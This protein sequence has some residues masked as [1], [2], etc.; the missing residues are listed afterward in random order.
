MAD[1]QT[2]SQISQDLQLGELTLSDYTTRSD[3]KVF[4]GVVLDKLYNALLAGTGNSGQKT[5]ADF[6][7]VLTSTINYGSVALPMYRDA[8]DL[9]QANNNKNIVLKFGGYEWTVTFLTRTGEGST[10]DHV[11][12]TLWLTDLLKTSSGNPVYTSNG[13]ANSAN[14]GNQTTLYPGDLYST[15]QARVEALNAGGVV[16]TSGN[17]ANTV[18]QNPNHQLAKFTMPSATGSLTDYI[19]KPNDVKY[20]HYENWVQQW[21]ISNGSGGYPLH[22]EALNE[23]NGNTNTATAANGAAWC[24]NYDYTGKT[25]AN[26]YTTDTAYDAWGNDY[27][28]LPS[29]SETGS[30]ISTSGSIGAIG[31]WK[32]TYN[33]NQN[34]RQPAHT[35]NGYTN[36]SNDGTNISTNIAVAGN[37]NYAWLRTGFSSIAH[38][39]YYLAGNGSYGVAY[40]ASQLAVRPA[41]HLDLTA[42]ATVAALETPRDVTQYEDSGTLKDIVYDYNKTWQLTDFG[43]GASW[44]DF[45]SYL[46]NTQFKYKTPGDTAAFTTAA[47]GAA[48]STL[49]NA[50]R[51]HVEFTLP[52]TS[53][54]KFENGA[55]TATCIITIKQKEIEYEPKLYKGNTPVNTITYGDTGGAVKLNLPTINDSGDL[56][57]AIKIYYKGTG[58][59]DTT[60]ETFDSDGY[61]SDKSMHQTHG[62]TTFPTGAGTS[63]NATIVDLNEKT[64]NYKLKLSSGASNPFAFNIGKK[65]VTLPTVSTANK[66]YNGQAQNFDIANYDPDVLDITSIEANG[67]TLSLNGTNYD[68]GNGKYTVTPSLTATPYKFTATE[69]AEYKVTWVI[70]QAA[71]TDY[72]WASTVINSD[73]TTIFTVDQASLDLTLNYPAGTTFPIGTTGNITVNAGGLTGILNSDPVTVNIGYYLKPPTGNPPATTWVQTDVDESSISLDMTNFT[74]TGTYVIWVQTSD[75]SNGSDINRNYKFTGRD[76]NTNPVTENVFVQQV[77]VGTGAVDVSGLKWGW[78]TTQGGTPTEIL[79]NS[80]LVYTKTNGAVQT[81][82]VSLIQN[83]IP[84]YLEV[85]IS[86]GSN[87]FTG[88]YAGNVERSATTTGYSAQV[89]LK[90][91]NS[92]YTFDSAD[93]SYNYISDTVATVNYTWYINAKELDFSDAVWEFS[94]NAIDEN[95]DNAQWTRFSETDTPEF[96]GSGYTYIRLNKTYLQN[97]G[98]DAGDYSVSYGSTNKQILANTSTTTN[99]TIALN[100]TNYKLQNTTPPHITYNWEIGNKKIHITGWGN[101]V[102][103][104]HDGKAYSIPRVQISNTDQDYTQFLEYVYSYQ[105]PPATPQTDVSETTMVS[106]VF[107][108]ADISNQISGTITVRLTTA[109]AQQ[110]ALD[111][112]TSWTFTCGASKTMV[113]VGIDGTHTE[114][115]DG[116]DFALTGTYH[117]GNVETLPEVDFVAQNGVKLEVT[118]TDKDGQV[119]VF[120]ANNAGDPDVVAFLSNAGVYTVD[121]KIT[122]AQLDN[123][124][125]LSDSQIIY[126]VARKGIVAPQVIKALT[127]TGGDVIFTD[128]LDNQYTANTSIIEVTGDN[129]CRNVLSNGSYNVSLKLLD[130]NYCWILPERSIGGGKGKIRVSLAAD[131]VATEL[132]LSPDLDRAIYSWN[133]APLKI[134]SSKMWNNGQLKLTPELANLVNNGFV[135]LSYNYYDSDNM[136]VGNSA[137]GFKPEGG[138]SYR[139]EAV[140]GG[141]DADMGNVVFVSS[142]GDIVGNT[143]DKVAY[144][145]KKTGMAKF[146]DTL[147]TK[148][149]G[150]PLWAWI[151]IG[152]CALILLIVLICIIVAACKRRKKKKEEEEAKKEKE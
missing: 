2:S 30:V 13:W 35:S 57:P 99:V 145:P 38:Y 110:Y 39:R 52:S 28:W 142:N 89:R 1:A 31:F 41:L 66:T 151:V 122:D 118:I 33:V 136:L 108:V 138:K 144:T 34:T 146:K 120:T 53:L 103:L 18:Q 70:K 59:P 141:D 102:T 32:T 10:S 129:N 71:Q 23:W 149:A 49:H 94:S 148:Y 74:S 93:T 147:T 26:G 131:E 127:F 62:S 27:V 8:Y 75:D 81:Y 130:N 124:Y 83:S 55:A 77:Q 98:L 79:T 133:V 5:I 113:T 7:G 44:Y 104:T 134:D 3:G 78:S 116:G 100:T 47:P 16:A 61:N 6:N 106:E 112:M 126:T 42:A 19:V 22:N 9:Y 63:Y 58:Y 21:T 115:D 43:K 76:T 36:G 107:P 80:D 123:A 119:K 109:G 51:Y 37:T 67:N 29:V 105:V 101:S 152:V 90:I 4:N 54:Y 97:L 132:E 125:A 46:S 95:D 40:P 17:S 96:T 45:A 85:D 68:D 56:A 50:G 128:H 72:T 117:P 114:Y 137:E 121:F 11:I 73:K 48:V 135:G 12:A 111:G 92:D 65:E 139:V 91:N 82:Y 64:S 140:L 15:S 88:G 84:S 60:N 150:L 69:A 14:G 143:S 86:Y 25:V 20:Q 87:G 24:S